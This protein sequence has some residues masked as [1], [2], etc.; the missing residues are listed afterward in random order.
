MRG[1]SI[2]LFGGKLL[3]SSGSIAFGVRPL[4]IVLI[5]TS[6]VVIF[7][8]LFGL[9]REKWVG[10]D[11]QTLIMLGSVLIVLGLYALFFQHAMIHTRF[12]VRMLVW[13]IAVGLF[14][15]VTEVID[16]AAW[17]REKKIDG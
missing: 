4:G 8:K 15:D 12:M 2:G 10:S 16:R 9:C 17:Q 6:F 14:A 1:A 7:L 5:V 3:F 13:P 11:L